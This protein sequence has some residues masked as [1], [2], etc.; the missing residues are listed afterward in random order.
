MGDLGF[1]LQPTYR[2]EQG[3]PVVLLYG[4][5]QNGKSFLVRDTRARPSFFIRASD[6]ER[7][8]RLGIE[9]IRT[10]KWTTFDGFEAA[11]IEMVSPTDARRL[12]DRLREHGLRVYESDVRFPTQYLW[13]R[14]IRGT[15]SIAGQWTRGKGAY[16]GIDQVYE[17]PELR[18][19]DWTPHLTVLSIDIETDP[20]AERLLSIA[21]F[22]PGVAEVLLHCPDDLEA[23]PGAVRLLREKDL[24]TTFVRRVRQIDPDVLTGWNFIDFDL[25]VLERLAKKFGVRLEIGRGRGAMRIR[26]S[27][28]PFSSTSVNIPGRVVLDGIELLRTSF[29]KMDRWGLG[30][31]AQEVL[32]E[33][34]LI[35][36][37]DRGQ[38]ILDA[39]Y[40]DRKKLVDYNL[41]DARLVL[42]IFDKLHLIELTVERSRL[43]GLPLPRVS[44]SIAAFE[45]RYL[46]QLSR[47]KIAAP[48]VGQA[49][50]SAADLGGYV[51]EPEVG[52]YDNVMI[53]DFKSLYPSLIR[54]FQIDPH[55]LLS[56]EQVDDD[57]LE[58]PNGAR[59][60]R[61][62]GILPG[63]LDQLFPR[64]EAAKR[65]DDAVAS[66][67]IKIL[68]NS[69]YGVLGT[70][71]CRFYRPGLAGAITSFGRELLRWSK[72]QLESYGYRVLYGDTDSLFVLSG[73]DEAD[74]AQALGRE[75]VERLNFDVAEHIRESWQMESRLE[76]EFEKLYRKLLLQSLRGGKGGARKRYAGLV[77]KGDAEKVE[78]VGLEAVRRD[79]TELA[80]D[81]QRE[82]YDR[83]FHGRDVQDF[84]SGV[85][86]D[87]RA[88]RLDEQ[89]T[90]VKAL[91]KPLDEYTATT[92]PH[93]AA[94]RKMS[95]RPGRLISYVMTRGGPEP[96]EEQRNAFDYEHYVQ[97]QVRPVAE[98]VL[99][100]LHL[101]FD[102]AIG[103]DAQMSLF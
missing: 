36:G 81:V 22:G 56:A 39:F 41:A 99:S 84:L 54:T 21:L 98:P 37:S 72:S 74:D 92:P 57:A 65:A 9:Q 24:L 8:A 43:T 68:M 13:Q 69:F 30:H 53:F 77:R 90:Y 12:G 7:A 55:G 16:Q 86:R 15:L 73:L 27:N 89:L 71:A 14:G 95:E 88:G 42:D 35:E 44:G 52:L 75:I 47:R 62:A 101:E 23:P 19:A 96:A 91:R 63:M 102:R 4:I 80:K 38:A 49:G 18:P 85:V 87:L 20:R 2:T 70:S 10:S 59:F 33:S 3:R 64:R 34:K 93:V 28:S 5:L 46:E 48:D 40:H 6:T 103:D 32:G 79:W 97:K 76:L 1:I 17:D 100:V 60:R 83:L 67:A 78:F 50:T 66:H 45:F 82:L 51:L 58:A 31:V 25:R 26:E 11:K 61:Q 29:V 94:A